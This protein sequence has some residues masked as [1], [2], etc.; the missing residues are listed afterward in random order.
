MKKVK[1]RPVKDLWKANKIKATQV[2]PLSPVECFISAGRTTSGEIL[3]WQLDRCHDRVG[4][5]PTLTEL[6][7][8][9]FDVNMYI[10]VRMAD[11]GVVTLDTLY[12]FDPSARIIE[13]CYFLRTL[14]RHLEEACSA[15]RRLTEL[16]LSIRSQK[17]A[18][19][20]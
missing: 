8:L 3:G 10:P 17:I 15:R 19:K 16:G 7:E 13:I 11:S 4:R 20:D 14:N 12:G 2:C 18:I 1:N 5:H 6:V 9:G